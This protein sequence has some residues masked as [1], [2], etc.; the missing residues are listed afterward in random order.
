MGAWVFIV[1]SSLLFFF[2]LWLPIFCVYIKVQDRTYLKLVALEKFD[3]QMQ[4]VAI[5]GTENVCPQ[6]LFQVKSVNFFAA[7]VLDLGDFFDFCVAPS[8]LWNRW[9]PNCP[10]TAY[11]L[12]ELWGNYIFMCI[13]LN[14]PKYYS[15]YE[16]DLE[17]IFCKSDR[18]IMNS[19]Y[20]IF[21]NSSNVWIFCVLIQQDFNFS[22]DR[23]HY[24]GFP[25]CCPL[26][27]QKFHPK[28][29]FAICEILS[30]P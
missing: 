27:A 21:L 3:F 14:L 26:T 16:M 18:Y 4:L 12:T 15:W 28:I 24:W 29:L 19:E 30:L 5:I 7:F 22:H 13:Y 9:F 6:V 23:Q 17:D 8:W 1:K 10:Q 11:T 20:G 2:M 25:A